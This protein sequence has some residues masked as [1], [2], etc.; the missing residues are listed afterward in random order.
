MA[1][2]TNWAGNQAC[3]P[4]RIAAPASEAEAVA[5]V[6]AAIAAG[7]PVRPVAAGHSFSPVCV[8]GGLL[9]E[10]GG[11]AGIVGVDRE[12]RHVRA[13]PGTAISAF[14]DRLWA[15]GLALA[16]Q[17]DIDTQQIA[18]AIATGTH[19]S[20]L[21]LGSFSS[22]LRRVRL[23]TGT[24]DVIE[25][26]EDRPELLHAAQVSLG[27]LGMMLE[28]EIEVSAAYRLRERI[29]N[30]RYAEV[31]EE[32]DSLIA[33]HRHFSFFWLPSAPSGELYGL[34]G[35][36]DTC[37]VKVYDEAAPDEPDDATPGRRIDRGYRIYPAVF[38]PNF[39]ELEYFVPIA[40]GQE[41]VAAM[42][43]L[44]LARLPDSIFPLEVRTTSGDDAHLSSN[45]GGATTV[46]SVAGVPGTD[47][48][49][50][51]REVDALLGSFGAR[52]HWGKLHF[53]TRA[54]LA[55]RY[56]AS[57]RFIAIRRELDPEGVFLNDHLRELFA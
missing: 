54:Q 16:N 35:A 41:A 13:L 47:Y 46:L 12:R 24:G 22:S 42:R 17:G 15:D 3:A 11:L 56:P 21:A 7:E 9:L 23:V 36:A 57:E 28:L 51:L 2:W 33:S 32:W 25:I 43:E 31:M 34:S 1:S 37:Y 26:G 10:S 5:L 30:R 52:V 6:R 48:W 45:H 55:E 20:G 29:E 4:A 44:M 14:G 18:G 39:H 8:T 19:G 49:S 50:Y 53:L 27:L 40:R 38:E